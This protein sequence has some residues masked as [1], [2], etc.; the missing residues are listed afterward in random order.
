M[1]VRS[2]ICYRNEENTVVASYC[3]NDGYPGWVGKILIRSYTELQK[4]KDLVDWGAKS[5]IHDEIYNPPTDHHFD[6]PAE[7]H[8]V[9]YHR[10]RGEDLSDGSRYPLKIED[11]VE[12]GYEWLPRCADLFMADYIYIFEGNNWVC[13]K[14]GANGADE[15][16]LYKS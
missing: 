10:G 11:G 12:F 6:K 3:H 5:S 16:D 8:T 15:I 2:A 4:V 7:G 9:F 14:M 13:F 1:S